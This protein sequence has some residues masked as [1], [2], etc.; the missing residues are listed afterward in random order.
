MVIFILLG[1]WEVL[2][3]K[4]KEMPYYNRPGVRLQ[5]KGVSVLSD[6][7]LLAVVLGR[8][9]FTENAV[10]QANR[11]LSVYNFD[12]LV[13]LSV[14]ELEV[15]FRNPVKAMKIRAMFEIFRRTN[16]LQRKGFKQ[17]VSSAE[18]VFHF[19]LDELADKKKEQFHA[20]L[21]DT[22]NHII[23][24]ALIAVGTLNASLIHPR[25]VFNP[26][27]KASA[28]AVVLVHNHP[29]GDCRP[30]REDEEV[31]K[32]LDEAGDVLGIK[33]VDHVI[34]GSDGFTSL[35]EKGFV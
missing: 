34:I 26:A 5:R 20:L 23:G 33:V 24:D 16:R 31:T 25:E 32:L 7:E 11:V 22:K 18:D 6:A 13:G 3:V 30:S 1:L 4:I 19:Y 12:R 28:N 2:C 8:G 17:K 10:D 9:D 15:E 27:V 21:L 29:S 35:R 14:H